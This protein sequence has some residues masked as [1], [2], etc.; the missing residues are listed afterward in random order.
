MQMRALKM[1]KALREKIREV[2]EEM[3][4]HPGKSFVTVSETI[5]RLMDFFKY[6]R[7]KFEEGA[8]VVQRDVPEGEATT[9]SLN[10][11]VYDSLKEL[12]LKY[13]DKKVMQSMRDMIVRMIYVWDKTQRGV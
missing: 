6:N 5:A 11:D 9:I 3:A 13:G 10:I 8:L 1:K 12:S 7:L 4:P 2:E